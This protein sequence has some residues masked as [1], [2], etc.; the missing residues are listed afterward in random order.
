[1][2]QMTLFNQCY[3]KTLQVPVHIFPVRGPK[4]DQSIFVPWRKSARAPASGEVSAD[5][6]TEGSL[7]KVYRAFMYLG[8]ESGLTGVSPGAYR[9]SFV[10]SV[11]LFFHM[12][13]LI[14]VHFVCKLLRYKNC[15]FTCLLNIH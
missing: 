5:P 4:E 3:G 13:E 11:S 15:F 14:I 2:K 12:D 7:R 10:V 1:M 8:I 6:A 9:F